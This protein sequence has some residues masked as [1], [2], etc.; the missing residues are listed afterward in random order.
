M[1]IC[2]K[3]KVSLLINYSKQCKTSLAVSKQE[4]ELLQEKIT[5]MNLQQIEKDKQVQGKLF[6][7]FN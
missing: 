2:N 5:T 3:K 7:S 1:R 4:I 6:T